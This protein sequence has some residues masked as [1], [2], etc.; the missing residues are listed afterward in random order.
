LHLTGFCEF[1][2]VFVV[3]RIFFYRKRLIVPIFKNDCYKL[4]SIF[5]R[6]SILTIQYDPLGSLKKQPTYPCAPPALEL[7]WYGH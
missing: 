3:Y 1:K 6:V 2:K 5:N 4:E 7:D